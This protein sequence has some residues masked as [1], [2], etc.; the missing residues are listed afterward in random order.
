MGNL[1][2]AVIPPTP[3]LLKNLTREG[4]SSDGK[5]IKS[6]FFSKRKI[7]TKKIPSVGEDMEQPEYSYELLDAK[8]VS[9]AWKTYLALP[10][11][12]E[13]LHTFVTPKMHSW[14]WSQE[15]C[16]SVFTKTYVLKGL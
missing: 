11:K 2:G 3:T 9:L 13:G 10:P 16:I 14:V 7:S 1:P 15:K 8:L 6:G 12:G 4:I 5:T